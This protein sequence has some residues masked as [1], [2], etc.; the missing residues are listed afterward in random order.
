MTPPHT[1]RSAHTLLLAMILLASGCGTKSPRFETVDAM[2]EA[3]PRERLEP[4]LPPD[5]SIDSPEVSL[6]RAAREFFLALSTGDE[7]ALKALLTESAV[8]RENSSS[9]TAPALTALM[10]ISMSLQPGP[11]A[12]TPGISWGRAEVAEVGPSG[13]PT[14]VLLEVSGPEDYRGMWRLD[15]QTELG[16][17]RVGQVIVPRAK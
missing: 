16:A 1:P 11:D 10:E 12:A 9:S 15:F 7:K 14:T 3:E 13:Q 6:E 2:P 17:F 4:V 5:A 8:L